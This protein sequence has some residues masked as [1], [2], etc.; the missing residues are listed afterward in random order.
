MTLG[1]FFF[2]YRS[3][4]PVP[5]LIPLF[6]FARPTIL[7]MA[8]GFVFVLIGQIVRFWG[9][10]YAGSETRTRNVGASALV[11][12]GPF[13]Y[14]RN[15]L[16]LANILIY[17]GFGLMANSLAPFLVIIGLAYF[18]FQYYHIILEEE[19]TLREKFKDK[20]GDYFQSV[21]QLIPR[22][23]PYHPAK[24][25]KLKLDFKA[26]YKSEKRTL[27]ANLTVVVCIYI[28][29]ILINQ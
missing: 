3:Y 9:V 12:Q 20:Y 14:S 15:P 18:I 26:G 21:N 2:K 27:Q 19:K 5:F 11:T 22:T 7:T 29:Y 8:I 1:Q 24:Q 13:A 28:V 10:S 25:S 6:L 4:T 16:Y 23:T 17:F